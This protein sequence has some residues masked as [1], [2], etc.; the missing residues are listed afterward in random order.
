MEGSYV[1][2]EQSMAKLDSSN[3]EGRIT[4]ALHSLHPPDD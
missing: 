3:D 2:S 1:F 4:Q